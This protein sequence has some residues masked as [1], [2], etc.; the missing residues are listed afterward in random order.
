MVS[1][2]CRPPLRW[3]LSPLS[4]QNCM[5]WRMMAVFESDLIQQSQNILILLQAVSAAFFLWEMR[6]GVCGEFQ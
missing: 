6:A 1:I 3:L 5:K 2:W 4:I